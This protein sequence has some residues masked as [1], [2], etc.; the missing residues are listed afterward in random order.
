VRLQTFEQS[1]N[2]KNIDQLKPGKL[3]TMF[4]KAPLPG[5]K[6]LPGF[7][8]LLLLCCTLTAQTLTHAQPVPD[9]TIGHEPG[10]RPPI[11]TAGWYPTTVSYAPDESNVVVTA[12]TAERHKLWN[13]PEPAR[14]TVMRYQIQAQRWETLPEINNEAFYTHVSYTFD[15]SAI[16][17]QESQ[18]QCTPGSPDSYLQKY[19]TYLVLLDLNGK[20]IR[21]L[22]THSDT[23]VHPS[24][25]KDANKILFWGVSNQLYANMGGGAW[26]VKEFDIAT[27]KVTQ[28]T[29]Y[30]AGFPQATPRYMPDGKRLMLAAEEYP[31]APNQD[32][33][34][35]TEEKRGRFRTNY[36]GKFG[37]NMTVVVDQPNAAIRPYFST[38]KH[39]WL[40]VRDISRDGK[41]AVFDRRGV[42]MCFRF[43]EEP[44]REEQCFSTFKTGQETKTGHI[45]EVVSASISPSNRTVA[46]IASNGKVG[47][48]A[49]LVLTDV[50][51]GATQIIGMRW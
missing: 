28:K 4:L 22:T 45:S 12:C 13:P 25:T 50:A 17:A 5:K 34:Y 10:R 24:L 47:P 51:T 7:A 32:D 9:P 30:Q 2:L 15:G 49:A 38:E 19:C 16:F 23:Y 43:I 29:D 21:N 1:I 44:L 41:L 35:V 14:C 26:D 39:M 6:C 48:T 46:S 37:R 11:N 36:V 20:K 40:I 3:A 33:F 31:K 8:A 18:A 27:Q 42:G